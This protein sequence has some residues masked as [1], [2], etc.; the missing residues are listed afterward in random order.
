MMS[1]IHFILSLSFLS[2][3]IFPQHTYAYP[4]A[5]EVLTDYNYPVGLLPTGV[6]GYLL[7]RCTGKFTVYL[8]QKCHFSTTSSYPLKFEKTITGILSKDRISDIRGVEAKGLLFG[9]YELVEVVRSDDFILINTDGI[10]GVKMPTERFRVSPGCDCGFRCNNSASPSAG[11][12]VKVEEKIRE[13]EDSSK[14]P[15]A[16]ASPPTSP[17]RDDDVPKLTAQL[18]EIA[19]ELQQINDD[20]LNVTLLYEEVMRVRDF[21]EET[22]MRAF[23]HLVKNENA[24]NGFLAKSEKHRTMAIEGFCS[25]K[26]DGRPEKKKDDEEEDELSRILHGH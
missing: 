17:A 5:Y 10:S 18:D 26:D 14:Q 23:D 24:G 16:P 1:N 21:D 7:D 3:V 4:D 6:E 20:R 12:A 9:W 19:K 8:N 13:T 25:K 22:L 11:A 15:I 2:T